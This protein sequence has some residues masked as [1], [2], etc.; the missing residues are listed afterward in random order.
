ML[1]YLEL[2]Y[3]MTRA[4]RQSNEMTTPMYVM[5]NSARAA[6]GLSGVGLRS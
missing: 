2:K 3:V 1:A 5:T 4:A 6:S